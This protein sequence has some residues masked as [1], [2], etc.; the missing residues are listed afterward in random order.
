MTSSLGKTRIETMQE[1]RMLIHEVIQILGRS[2]I[3]PEMIRQA[4]SLAMEARS[5][6]TAQLSLE[7]DVEVARR[8]ARQ[9]R[10]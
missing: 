2:R 10:S 3:D 5:T 1:A 8:I 4:R 9:V 6:L 7:G